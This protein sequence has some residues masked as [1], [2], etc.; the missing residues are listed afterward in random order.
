MVRHIR[1]VARFVIRP[2]RNVGVALTVAAVPVVVF[3]NVLR[4]RIDQNEMV[5]VAV[6]RDYCVAQAVFSTTHDSGHARGTHAADLRDLHYSRKDGR[7][8][9]LVPR[10]VADATGPA[11][12]IE[13]YFFEHLTRHAAWG[14]IDPATGFGLA[15]LPAR[16]GVTGRHTFVVDCRGQVYEKDTGSNATLGGVYPDVDAC[17]SGWRMV[18]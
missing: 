16:Y 18:R 14:A 6:L 12:A 8:V 9:C 1:G 11:S 5:A 15:A 2:I 13:G 10:E 4:I 17:G 3:H 7:P